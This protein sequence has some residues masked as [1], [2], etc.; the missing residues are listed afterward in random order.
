M[1]RPLTPAEFAAAV[2]HGVALGLRP[3]EAARWPALGRAVAAYRPP[4]AMAIKSDQRAR[5][6]R[7]YLAWLVDAAERLDLPVP[8]AVRRWP[9]GG[10]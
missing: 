3:P 10:R 5:Q 4:M 6:D 8:E 9:R 2:R 1:N 7:D